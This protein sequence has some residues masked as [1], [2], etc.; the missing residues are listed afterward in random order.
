EI[1]LALLEP[2]LLEIDC[3]ENGMEAVRM[4][5]E[6]PEKYDLIFMDIQ[7]PEMDGYEASRQIRKFET[8]HP[9]KNV[10]EFAE[11]NGAI[12]MDFPEES[13]KQLLGHSSGVPIIAMSA[14]VFKE[15]IEKSLEAG[16]NGH[17]G[18]PLDFDEVMDKL[19]TYLL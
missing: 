5:S 6:T 11:Q 15:D 8:E 12:G 7:M 10:P 19:R 9:A 16:M 4:Y 2:T 1:V 13:P 14:N 18:K 17:I 3:A